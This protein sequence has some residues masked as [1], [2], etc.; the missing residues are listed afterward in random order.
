MLYVLLGVCCVLIATGIVLLAGRRRKEGNAAGGRHKGNAVRMDEL[1]TGRENATEKG[2]DPQ[3]FLQAEQPAARPAGGFPDASLQ[4]FRQQALDSSSGLSMEEPDS[5]AEEAVAVP[6]YTSWDKREEATAGGQGIFSGKNRREES[7]EEVFAQ[8]EGNLAERFPSNRLFSDHLQPGSPEAVP[9]RGPAESGTQRDSRYSEKAA[10]QVFDASQRL[11][12]FKS[13]ELLLTLTD[14]LKKISAAK[15]EAARKEKIEEMLSAARLLDAKSE[16]EEYKRCFEKLD[17]SFWEAIEERSS[18]AMT[19][20]EQRLCALLSMG[21]G[22]K[23]IAELTNR[24]VRTVETTIYKIRKK[25][26]ME[27]EDKTQDYLKHLIS[28]AC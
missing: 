28:N 10:G 22:T 26:G 15:D 19:P 20:Y 27:A 2:S 6:P 24:S 5:A 21:M 3:V 1:F 23:E 17:P 4:D 13:H 25:L 12:L 9:E 18:E 14:G 8:A 7:S 11:L 16:W